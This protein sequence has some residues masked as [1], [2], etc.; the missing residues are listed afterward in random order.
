ME[1]R[2]F[3][4]WIACASATAG[5]VV[6]GTEDSGPATD[7]PLAEVTALS[8]A[9]GDPLPS[10]SGRPNIG[11]AAA[12]RFGLTPTVRAL[13][14]TVSGFQIYR[15]EASAGGQPA[16]ALRT[17]LAGLAGSTLTRA[18]LPTV[19]NTYH[20]RTDFG[21]LVTDAELAAMGLLDSA[22]ARTQAPT[23]QV[24]F[25]NVGARLETARREIV[26]GRVIAQDATAN[27]QRDIPELLIEVR[28]RAISTVLAGV[29]VSTGATAVSAAN[30][31]AASDYILR[32]NTV[33]GVAPAA[34][35]CTT[36]TLGRESQRPYQAA[37]YFVDTQA[38]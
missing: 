6:P 36:A 10:L 28:G 37:Y 24:T 25:G 35:A 5:C 33:G 17:P 8:L 1:I 29:T 23:W 11:P 13:Y 3:V 7:E 27:P 15:C 4:M 21:S 16:W 20:A 38:H 31:I 26:A 18:A 2:N 32:L 30:P 22:G 34:S 19:S 9:T 14:Q 12:A